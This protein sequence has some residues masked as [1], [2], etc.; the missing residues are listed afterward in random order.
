MFYVKN[1]IDKGAVLST[2]M[3]T[4]VISKKKKKKKKNIRKSAFFLKKVKWK[5]LF[6]ESKKYFF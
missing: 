4:I 1:E 6:F 5:H 3:R 2:S